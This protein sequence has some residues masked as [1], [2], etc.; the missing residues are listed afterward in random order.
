[1]A[2]SATVLVT[3]GGV[4]PGDDVGLTGGL[5]A[6]GTGACVTVVGSLDDELDDSLAMRCLLSLARLRAL[7]STPWF[8]SFTS[9]DRIHSGRVQ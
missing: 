8:L 2:S 1:M 7:A 3:L 9:R 6:H 4:I 5:S